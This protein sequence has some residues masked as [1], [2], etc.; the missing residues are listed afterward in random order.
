MVASYIRSWL[1]IPIC[2][3]LSNVLITK[4]KFGL[5]IYPSSTKFVQYQT[6]A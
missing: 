5:N 3:T 2:G 1:E 4:T 6:V